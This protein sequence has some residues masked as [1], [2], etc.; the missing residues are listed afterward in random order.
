MVQKMVLHTQRPIPSS[1]PCCHSCQA[2]N[3]ECSVG[4]HRNELGI[5]GM[6]P[7]TILVL[8]ILSCRLPWFTIPLLVGRMAVLS[9]RVIIALQEWQIGLRLT[10]LVSLIPLAF[11]LF[12]SS[13]QRCP[14]F[15]TIWD[16]AIQSNSEARPPV[17]TD[18]QWCIL[19]FITSKCCLCPNRVAC[20]VADKWSVMLLFSESLGPQTNQQLR[21]VSSRD[22]MALSVVRDVFSQDAMRG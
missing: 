7:H 1:L 3:L 9:T 10:M 22:Q 4:W 21:T 20:G 6:Q 5:Y 12:I 16:D 11:S 13:Y 2:V 18:N 14:L 17:V 8:M 15:T 19:L